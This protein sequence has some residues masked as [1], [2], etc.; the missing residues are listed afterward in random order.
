MLECRL[1]ALEENAPVSVLL[2]LSE[3]PKGGNAAGSTACIIED[4]D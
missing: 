3:R 4:D 1:R 2:P